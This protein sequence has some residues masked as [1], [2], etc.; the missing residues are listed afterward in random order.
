V[1]TDPTA[2]ARVVQKF[3]AADQA[4]ASGQAVDV[5]L[6]GTWS[7]HRAAAVLRWSIPAE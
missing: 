5:Q 4:K 1:P 7:L 3:A 2:A 6:D